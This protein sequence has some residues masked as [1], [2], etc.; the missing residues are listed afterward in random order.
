MKKKMLIAGGSGYLGGLI[1]QHFKSDYKIYVLTRSEKDSEDEDIEYIKWQTD[2]LGEWSKA[3]ENT[4]VLINLSGKNINTQFTEKNRK[5]ILSSRIESTEILAKAV[6]NAKNPPKIWLNASSVAVYEESWNTS[7]TEDDKSNGSD[8]LSKVSQAW[9]ESFY[10]APNEKTKKAIFRIS[11][12]LGESKGS[13]LL[14]LKQLIKLGAGGKAGN[15]KQMVSWLS[16][17]DFVKAIAFII[18]NELS[19]AFNFCT[20]SPISN[21]NFMKKL[22]KKYK[23]PFGFPAPEFLLK[24]GAKIIDTSPEL[25][26]RSQNV[27]PKKLLDNGFEFEI[28]DLEEL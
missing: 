11:M 18:D 12:I 7:K 22:R 3:V 10:S 20:P 1:I 5:A 8:F 9:E 24:I 27:V 6:D 13:A 23:I 4:D 17:K 14:T 15:G 25:V 2:S 28:T 19:G 21:D 16:E 26:L